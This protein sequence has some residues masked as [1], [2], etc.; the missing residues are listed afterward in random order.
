MKVFWISFSV[1]F[2]LATIIGC[3]TVVAWILSFIKKRKLKKQLEHKKDK[4]EEN[5]INCDNSSLKK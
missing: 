1:F 4:Q 3:L 5:D 2:M